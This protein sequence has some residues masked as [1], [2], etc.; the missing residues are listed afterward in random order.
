MAHLSTFI[1]YFLYALG[2][3]TVTLIGWKWLE[4]NQFLGPK[5]ATP[6]EWLGASEHELQER[7]EHLE[8]GLTLLA[9][10]ASAAPFIGLMG[11]VL[12]IVEALRNLGAGA[13]DMSLIGGPIATALNTTLV[14]LFSAVPAAVAHSFFQRRVELMESRHRRYLARGGE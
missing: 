14:G 13:P 1:D 3:V 9:A 11:T 10:I 7:L 6:G 2:F 8:R 4:L 12:H 5:A